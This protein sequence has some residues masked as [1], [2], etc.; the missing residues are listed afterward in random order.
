MQ[1][2]VREH[3]MLHRQALILRAATY[4]LNDIDRHRL[5]VRLA[6]FLLAIGICICQRLPL[7][8]ACNALL[9]SQASIL[10]LTSP[11]LHLL[12]QSHKRAARSVVMRV[13]CTTLL[14]SLGSWPVVAA[15]HHFFTL[16]QS[17]LLRLTVKIPLSTLH[18]AVAHTAVPCHDLC[19]AL[20]L[21]SCCCTVAAMLVFSPSARLSH[22]C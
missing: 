15:P 19:S 22:Y 8:A 10:P 11:F 6:L 16:P 14:P 7:N 1:I 18:H 12:L 17:P 5:K 9:C 21:F 2:M 13:T 20:P 4:P 3:N